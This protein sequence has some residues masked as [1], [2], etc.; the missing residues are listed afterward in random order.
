MIPLLR[1]FPAKL[2]YASPC[3][4]CN[5][6]PL[7]SNLVSIYRISSAQTHVEPRRSP[8]KSDHNI[9]DS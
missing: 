8:K 1:S 3:C 6:S 4:M 7:D 5:A 9:T 2:L